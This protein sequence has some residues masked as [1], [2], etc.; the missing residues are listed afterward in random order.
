MVLHKPQYTMEFIH[1]TGSSILVFFCLFYH[2]DLIKNPRSNK[3]R[4]PP[5]NQRCYAKKLSYKESD[6]EDIEVQ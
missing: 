2:N 6:I 5:P 4:P 1:L 3:H